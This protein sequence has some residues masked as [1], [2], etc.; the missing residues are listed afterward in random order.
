MS[1]LVDTEDPTREVRM[2]KRSEAERGKVEGIFG[3]GL[4]I[5]W[6]VD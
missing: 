1:G 3:C 5:I 6:K 2:R 4:R